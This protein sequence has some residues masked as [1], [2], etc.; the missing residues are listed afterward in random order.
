MLE[1]EKQLNPDKLI[2]YLNIR[3]NVSIIPENTEPQNASEAYYNQ[4]TE[5]GGLIDAGYFESQVALTTDHNLS[6]L[7]SDFWKHG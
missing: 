7:S 4:F 6:Q 2:R 5:K 3:A 1:D